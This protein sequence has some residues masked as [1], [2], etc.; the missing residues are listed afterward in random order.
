MSLQSQQLER[1]LEHLLRQRLA[2][3]PSERGE[4]GGEGQVAGDAMQLRSALAE[5]DLTIASQVM[6]KGRFS[7]ACVDDGMS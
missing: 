3:P 7:A 1:E 6:C 5:R 4:G 2:H